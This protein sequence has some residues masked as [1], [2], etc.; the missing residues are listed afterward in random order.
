MAQKMSMAW[1]SNDHDH[2]EFI[3]MR[4]PHGKGFAEIAI[5]QYKPD[6]NE[7]SP[8]KRQYW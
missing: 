1:L 6:A 7:Q 5:S 2:I 4:G 3:R 8:T